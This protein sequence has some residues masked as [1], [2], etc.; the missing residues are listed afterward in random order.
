MRRIDRIDFAL[1]AAARQRL[2]ADHAAVQHEAVARGV[3]GEHA[4][5]AAAGLR[6]AFAANQ[7]LD[8]VSF[9][10]APGEPELGAGMSEPMF[11]ASSRFPAIASFAVMSAMSEL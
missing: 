3:V 8:G 10:V 1:V 11:D 4:C 6:K 9:A 2:R 7:V 5:E